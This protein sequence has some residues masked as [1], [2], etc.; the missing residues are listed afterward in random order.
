MLCYFRSIE[1]ILCIYYGHKFDWSQTKFLG[2]TKTKHARE[3]KEA[4]HSI[5][6]QT[7][8]RHIDIP[9]IY[10]QLK[11]SFKSHSSLLTF[12][13]STTSL[14][15]SKHDNHTQQR[16]IASNHTQSAENTRPIRRYHRLRQRQQQ[17][18]DSNI[19][20]HSDEDSKHRVESSKH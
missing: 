7:F 4:W 20:K 16:S 18:E 14:P 6:K 11:R 17:R 8:N 3:F 2:Q 1:H 13:P 10:L 9:T 15:T 12:N 5:D 19:P